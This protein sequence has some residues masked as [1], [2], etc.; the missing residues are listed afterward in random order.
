MEESFFL[1]IA[2]AGGSDM[3]IFYLK[4]TKATV[5][6]GILDQVFGGGTLSW[7][8]DGNAG[9]GR[10]GRANYGGAARLTYRR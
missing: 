4:H 10:N 5:A 8:V 3:T 1:R 9:V 2:A 7:S 6:A